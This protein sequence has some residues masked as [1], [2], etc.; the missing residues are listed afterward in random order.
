MGI[1]QIIK[2][3]PNHY[4]DGLKGLNRDLSVRTE[5]KMQNIRNTARRHRR[6]WHRKALQAVRKFIK[7]W[8]VQVEALVAGLRA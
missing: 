3:F 6:Q 4:G 1:S 5:K 8:F 7:C 2:G